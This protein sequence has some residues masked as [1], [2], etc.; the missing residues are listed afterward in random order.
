MS[1]RIF[2]KDLRVFGHHGVTAEEKR[3]GQ[4]FVIDVECS[5]DLSKAAATDDLADTVDYGRLVGAVT[6]IVTEESF[7]LL[8]ALAGR[9]V[10]EAFKDP[11][12]EKVVVRISKPAVNAGVELSRRR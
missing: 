10:D 8:E 5:L 3:A 6:R 12:I 1:D 11:R 4:H 2:I 7:D 9:V